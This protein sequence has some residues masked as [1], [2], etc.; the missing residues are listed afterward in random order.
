[1]KRLVLAV[2]L[3]AGLAACS[4]GWDPD[5]CDPSCPPTSGCGETSQGCG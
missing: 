4:G 3:V 5:P 2:L 1:M